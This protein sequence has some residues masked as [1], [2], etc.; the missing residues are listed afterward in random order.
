M[1]RVDNA[2]LQ[3]CVYLKSPQVLNNIDYV[4]QTRIWE[5]N[6][7][8]RTVSLVWRVKFVTE[9]LKHWILELG[10]SSM[11]GEFPATNTFNF[12][13]KRSSRVSFKYSMPFQSIFGEYCL[14]RFR[15]TFCFVNNNLF[16]PFFS[17]DD[18]FHRC[19]CRH[20][21]PETDTWVYAKIEQTTHYFTVT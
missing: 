12:Q 9:K 3:N 2:W 16:D 4:R 10:S 14:F 13:L 6:W 1:V 11:P 8:C 17:V 7:C 18:I 19:L 20:M 15:Q 21:L 5:F